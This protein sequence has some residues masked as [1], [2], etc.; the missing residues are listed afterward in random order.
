MHQFALL[1]LACAAAVILQAGAQAPGDVD[2]NCRTNAL[3][4]LPSGDDN[5]LEVLMDS[6]N[7]RVLLPSAQISGSPAWTHFDADGDAFGVCPR[8]M[9]ISCTVHG[10]FSPHAG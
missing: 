7:Y 9:R 2:E 8:R 4:I 5:N 3:P 1:L 10:I 6:Q